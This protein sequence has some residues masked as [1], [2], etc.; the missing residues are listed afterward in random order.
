[1]VR[2]AIIRF[3][4]IKEVTKT[5]VTGAN[6]FIGSALI[7][8]LVKRGLS[9]RGVS[10]NNTFSLRESSKIDYVQINDINENT[11]WS[12][13][14]SG[15]TN[16]IHCAGISDQSKWKGKNQ[17]SKY[18]TINVEG[19]KRL[20]EEAIK[21]NIKK[22]IF[23]STVKVHGETTNKEIFFYDSDISPSCEYSKSKFEAEQE[24]KKLSI[25][26]N[27]DFVIVRSPVVY[28]PGTKG[29]FLK[30][31]RLIMTGIPIPLDN[32]NNK[33]SLIGIN[34][35]I[36]F[37]ILCNTTKSA[38]GKT[39]LVS[40]NNDLSTTQII[41]KIRESMKKKSF[42]FYLPPKILKLVGY[43]LM[44]PSN[45]DRL[46]NSLEI[47]ITYSKK[48]LSWNPPFSVDNEIKKMSNFF[49]NNS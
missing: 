6:G 49:L 44:Q 25:G 24:I 23:L 17:L 39:F 21:F 45:I 35:L 13:A 41:K 9:V 36:D 7:K 46:I 4:K 3:S 11:D 32:I 34:N 38:S 26:T 27:L 2:S 12:I 14:L 10:R 5:L 47:D 33:R 19:T 18:R 40:D 22:I 29:N 31:M 20:V 15:I 16:I 30:L 28:G 42:L 37:L 8:E 1:M 48:T 43:I